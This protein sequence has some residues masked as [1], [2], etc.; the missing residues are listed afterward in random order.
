MNQASDLG[1]SPLQVACRTT[2]T[3]EIVTMLLAVRAGAAWGA[4]VNQ[5][6]GQQQ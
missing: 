5:A 2:A 1:F 4:A 3:T 6:T